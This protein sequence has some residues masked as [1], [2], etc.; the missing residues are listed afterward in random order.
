VTSRLYLK[1]MPLLGGAQVDISAFTGRRGAAFFDGQRSLIELG[2]RMK[3]GEASQGEFLVMD[4]YQDFTDTFLSGIPDAH[5]LVTWT[6]DGPGYEAWLFRG[7]VANVEGGR[8]VAK[9]EDEVEWHVTADDGN[10]DLRGQAFTTSWVRPEETDIQRLVALQL[11][12]L[13]GSSSTATH[14][15]DTCEIIVNTSHLAPNTNTVTMPAKKYLPGTQPM[16]VVQDCA[17]TAGKTFG[18]VIHH[19]GGSHLCLLYIVNNDHAT[20]ASAAKISDQVDDWDPDNASTPVW[21]PHWESGYGNVVEMQSRLSALVG[22]WGAENAAYAEYPSVEEHTDYWV[23]AYHDSQSTTQAQANLRT[24]GILEERRGDN[25][26]HRV[27]VIVTPE[28]VDLITAGM[29]IGIK[30]AVTSPFLISAV[31]EYVDKRIAECRFEPLPD[32]RYWAHLDLERPLLR[33]APGRGRVGPIPPVQSEP[34]ASAVTDYF[35]SFAESVYDDTTGLYPGGS[36][37]SSV[38]HPGYVHSHVLMPSV[39]C[40]SASSKAPISPGT[41]HVRAIIAR[42]SE[43][44]NTGGIRFHATS[45]DG[46]TPTTIWTS[47]LVTAVDTPT[48]VESDIT[49]PAGADEFT[50]AVNYN[51]SRIYEVELTHG[52]S[53]P[54]FTGTDAPLAATSGTGTVGTSPIYSPIDH[55]HP[56]QTAS[57]TPIA[58]DGGYFIGSSVEDALQESA[59]RLIAVLTNKSGGSVDEGDVVV[60]DTTASDSFTTTT[61]AAKESSIGIALETIA[62]DATGRVML[63][64]IA[65]PVTVGASVTRGH[66]LYTSSVATEATGSATR[67]AGAFGQFIQSGTTPAAWIWGPADATSATSIPAVLPLTAVNGGVPELVWD[68]DNSLIP[69]E[70]V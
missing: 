39:G 31:G 38:W 69:T 9:V 34:P 6:E 47:G 63:A 68:D 36:L 28:Q 57:V 12:T 64:G 8:G 66:Y 55:Q 50:F 18:V 3:E 4:P 58:D 30:A 14:H 25:L 70:V 7:R 59:G 26:T 16:E 29:S 49:F 37:S 44:Y 5:W 48:T 32:G 23:D 1:K 62:N 42:A 67:T 11:Y 17:Q 15:R 56:V 61:T 35:W 19:D 13:N 60:V 65:H 33:V 53:T 46:S 52:G 21:E 41:Y 20:Y 24:A 51:T 22:I 27:S 2:M 45:W 40:D 10:I 54:G 43:T